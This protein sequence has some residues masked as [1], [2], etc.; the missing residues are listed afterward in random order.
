MFDSLITNAARRNGNPKSRWV[1]D[2]SRRFN[3]GQTRDPSASSPTCVA[4]SVFLVLALAAQLG[5]TISRFDVIKAHMLA[6]PLRTYFIRY[7]PGFTEFL[8]L[9][10]G[11]APFNPDHFLLR[12]AKN[13]YGA[14]DAGRV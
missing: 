2:G 9:K 7:P 3:K 11:H 13:A 1:V 8:R 6:T 5:W 10:F 12:A 4:I 14:P